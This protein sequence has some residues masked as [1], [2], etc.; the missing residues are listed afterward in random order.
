M[1]KNNNGISAEIK[2]EILGKIKIKGCVVSKLA[3]SYNVSTTS[4]YNWQREAGATCA[5]EAN[6]VELSVKEP[7]SRSLQKASL[8]FAK[9]SLVIEGELNTG[10]L[11]AIVQILDEQ[12]C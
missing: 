4:I 9:F 7:Q 1:S 12:T 3:K 8:V 2:A 6:F 10:A 5:A 11:I